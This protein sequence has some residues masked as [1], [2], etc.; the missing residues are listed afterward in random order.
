M[1]WSCLISS[2]EKGGLQAP[3]NWHSDN[4][5][6]WMVSGS[7]F[8]KVR[9]ET[10]KLCLSISC[11]SGTRYCKVTMHRRSEMLWADYSVQCTG[12]VY[13]KPAAIVP[14]LCAMPS[15]RNQLWNDWHGCC[16]VEAKLRSIVVP[17]DL[18]A[19]LT[20][21]FSKAQIVQKHSRVW[22]TAGK[23]RADT[24]LQLNQDYRNIIEGL[25]VSCDQCSL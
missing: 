2:S 5:G 6:S 1:L 22:I 11:H 10:A 8:N 24:A 21:L 4:D 9:P 17:A 14:L 18:E 25:Q 23:T 19:Q 3:Q 7:K 20:A 12:D 15:F 13:H 16:D